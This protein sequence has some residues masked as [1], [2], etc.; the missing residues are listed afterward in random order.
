MGNYISATDVNNWPDGY[1]TAQKDAV[2]ER[3]ES[4]IERVTGDYFYEK[5]EVLKLDG[6][7]SNRIFTGRAPDLLSISSITAYGTLVPSSVYTFDAHSIYM[8]PELI[9]EDPVL[10]VEYWHLWP[11]G[12][13]NI[14]VTCTIGWS[15]T[16]EAIKNAAV[17]L[18]EAENDSTLYSRYSMNQ[19]ESTKD[20]SFKRSERFMT[21]VLEAD[22]ILHWYVKRVPQLWAV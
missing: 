3:V 11:K 21:G 15:S 13:N 6:N 17:I 4:L 19:S 18:A 5:S 16:P 8:D 14:V 12:K 9:V 2:I 7:G 1:T 20:Y 10:A 22:R